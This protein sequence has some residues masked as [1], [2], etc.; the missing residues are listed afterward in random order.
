VDA[1]AALIE[2]KA[3]NQRALWWQIGDAL[4]FRLGDW[5]WLESSDKTQ[6]LFYLK[7]DRSE[8][9]DLAS[10]NHDRIKEMEL[11]WRKMQ[12][13]FKKDMTEPVVVQQ[14]GEGN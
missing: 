12:A 10:A 11:Q 7:A 2:N 9:R 8:T 4:A 3:L 1:S 6:E 13:R 14:K 5:K